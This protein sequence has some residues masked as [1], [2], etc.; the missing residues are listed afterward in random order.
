MRRLR[1]RG[2]AAALV[3]ITFAAPAIAGAHEVTVSRSRGSFSQSDQPVTYRFAG[4]Y[5]SWV[6]TAVNSEFQTNYANAATNNSRAPI[7][8]YSSSG[9][10]LVTYS[11]ALLSPCNQ[12]PNPD[13]LACASNWG[14]T[15]FKVYIR[16]FATAPHPN[17]WGWYEN[18]NS[19]SGDS[20]A[21]TPSARSSTNS[22]TRSLPSATTARV[23]PI[24]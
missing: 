18:D 7:L 2:A 10:A 17:D 12:D 5:P 14:T 16:N 19:C 15:G 3:L 9:T 6:T 22:A 20:A 21:S 23:R 8:S 11:N 1:S 4:T 24:P 13:W